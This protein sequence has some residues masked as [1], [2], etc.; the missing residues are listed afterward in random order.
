MR[1]TF[2][3]GWTVTSCCAVVQYNASLLQSNTNKQIQS[4]YLGECLE[5][6]S[7][8]SFLGVSQ[9]QPDLVFL[10]RYFRD[11]QRDNLP[12]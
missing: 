3:V 11:Y 2:L 7:K 10:I 5:G 1:R 12:S 4:M 6:R 8:Y 9:T